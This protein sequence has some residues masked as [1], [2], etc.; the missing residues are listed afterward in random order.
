MSQNIGVQGVSIS[1][2]IDNKDILLAPIQS[3]YAQLYVYV[4]TFIRLPLR[5]GLS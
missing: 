3:Y 1:Q 5:S 2:T 4:L